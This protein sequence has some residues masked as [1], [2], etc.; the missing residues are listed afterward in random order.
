MSSTNKTTHYELPLYE[1]NDIFNPL[2]DSND[3]MEKIDTALYDIANAEG[4][5]ASEIVSIKS[6]LDGAEG[7]IDDLEAQ[8]GDDV[9]VTTAQTLSGAINELDGDVSSL[10]GRLDIVEDD[11]NNETTGLKVKV[12]A[13]ENTVGGADSGLVKDVADLQSQNG[14]ETLTTD[15]STLSGGINELNAKVGDEELNTVA[16]T[17]IGGI[18]EV[19]DKNRWDVDNKHRDTDYTFVP[20][21]ITMDRLLSESKSFACWLPVD[22]WTPSCDKTI[23]NYLH[24]V[25]QLLPNTNPEN[26]YQYTKRGVVI[27]G[28]NE[29]APDNQT[30]FNKSGIFLV[31][32]NM[33]IKYKI[34]RDLSATA[35][36]LGIRLNGGNIILYLHLYENGVYYETH[37]NNWSRQRLNNDISYAG[38]E[39][40][41]FYVFVNGTH[42]HV[43]TDDDINGYKYVGTFTES[44]GTNGWSG[45]FMMLSDTDTYASLL[46]L[47]IGYT[48]VAIADTKYIHYDDTTPYIID[49]KIYMTATLQAYGSNYT[50]ILRHTLGCND[51]ELVGIISVNGD[52]SALG[53]D[54]MFDRKNKRFVGVFRQDEN[55]VNVVHYGFAY[56]TCLTGELNFTATKLPS[57]N[58]HTGFGNYLDDEDPAVCF[59]NGKWYVGINRKTDSMD[60]DYYYDI[61]VSATDEFNVEGFTYVCSCHHT[62]LTGASFLVI[63][64][65]LYLSAGD[66]TTVSFFEIPSGEYVGSLPITIANRVWGNVT[67]INCGNYSK[68][69]L[70]TFDR[71]IYTDSNWSYGNL[72]M[73]KSSITLPEL[74]TNN[75][76]GT[77]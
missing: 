25:Y 24:N 49:N 31:R 12:S 66:G 45:I 27:H 18:N 9:L 5:D 16:Q 11:I 10:D 8:C 7:D 71:Q 51:L 2:V 35:G 50:G 17:I 38:A 69:F 40:V 30:R 41:T 14:N 1:D 34:K 39:E 55:G 48:F 23:E 28:I 57:V 56:T 73:F 75:T 61:F 52:Y 29:T 37:D 68:M 74:I 58:V 63:N 72:Q 26:Y 19:N 6:R 33:C 44:A 62:S 67:I 22:K 4:E 77:R 47:E 46:D 13:L 54:L 32:N 20:S 21:A 59:V 76:Y 15:A 42:I 64:G 70:T 3:A 43:Y 53:T 36:Y 65:T 60:W